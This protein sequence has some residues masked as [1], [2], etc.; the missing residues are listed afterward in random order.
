MILKMWGMQGEINVFFSAE[1][2]LQS[3]MNTYVHVNLNKAGEK[4]PSSR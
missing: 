1:L 3:C 4:L 2:C